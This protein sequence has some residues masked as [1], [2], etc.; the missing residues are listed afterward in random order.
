MSSNQSMLVIGSI[1]LLGMLIV[2]FYGANTQQM[3]ASVENEASIAATGIA[4]SMLDDIQNRA[5]DEFT[6]GSYT[7]SADSFTSV[8]SLGPES[9]ETSSALFD[10]IDD[11]NGYSTVDSSTRLGNYDISVDVAYITN[12]APNSVS[13]SKTFVKR[14][15]VNV[16]NTYMSDTLTMSHLIGY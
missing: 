11:F 7:T 9:G 8:V 4:Q 14:I 16:F 1:F 15:D 3:E 6:V 13:Y 12:F 5:Y 10:D 2:N